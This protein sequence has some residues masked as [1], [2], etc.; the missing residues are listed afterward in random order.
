MRKVGIFIFNWVNRHPVRSFFLYFLIVAILPLLFT[1]NT[2]IDTLNFKNTGQIGDTIGGIT[3]PFI[4]LLSA[5]LVYISFRQ[6]YLANKL[7][8]D[9][10]KEDAINQNINT[11]INR[12]EKAITDFQYANSNYGNKA[13]Y[14]FCSFARD[15]IQSTVNLQSNDWRNNPVAYALEF[16]SMIQIIKHLKYTINYL[17]KNQF[18]KSTLDFYFD[19]LKTIFKDSIIDNVQI[20][21]IVSDSKKTEEY[22][23]TLI[24]W[25][26][27]AK[28]DLNAVIKRIDPQW[29]H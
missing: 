19:Y 16:K 29:K 18:D 5:Y 6:Q 24:N 11:L 9:A 27:I 7:L 14:R 3:A 17:T 10:R 4:G 23:N 20:I 26:I 13:L 28:N 2:D 12:I 1:V 21:D 25:V 8:I 22:N 15:H